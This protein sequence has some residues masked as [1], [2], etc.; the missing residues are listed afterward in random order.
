MIR[1]KFCGLTRWQ[2]IECANLLKPDYIGFVFWKKSRRY[3][4]EDTARQLR[5]ALDKSITAVGVFVD[6]DPERVAHLINEGIIDA[7]QLHGGEDDEYIAKLRNLI[8]PGKVIIKAFRI[9]SD[10]DIIKAQ[11][12]TADMIL[13]DAGMGDGAAFDWTMIR[14]MQRP[15]YLAGGLD[16]QNVAK[17][18]EMLSPYGVD[19]SSGIETDG[20]KDPEKMK[21]F[22]G[23]VRSFEVQ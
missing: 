17:A 4:D 9:T 18:V 10:E 11:S 19:V 3:T 20:V 7:A 8:M 14:D 23:I 22:A 21:E 15:Y 16:C 13:L 6:E 5:S 1:I 2:D 12:S